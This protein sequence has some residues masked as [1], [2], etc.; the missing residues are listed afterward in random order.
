MFARLTFFPKERAI[1]SM[2]EDDS[3]NN[4]RTGESNQTAWA[5]ACMNVVI[6]LILVLAGLYIFRQITAIPEKGVRAIKN[7][8][9]E[10][11]HVAAAFNRGT[12]TTTFISYATQVEGSSRFQFA[13]LKQMEIFERKDE[14]ATGFG[15]I[16]LPDV[17]AEARA[18]VEFTY[19][20]DFNGTWKII[21]AGEVV[22]VLTPPIQFNKPAVD[23][24]KIKY[25]IKKGSILRRESKVQEELKES[26]TGLSIRRA[27]DNI[28]LVRE[29]GRKEV[30]SFVKKWLLKDFSDGANYR[31]TV[32]FPD[33]P[34]P[35]AF[36][37]S[38]PRQGSGLS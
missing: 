21:V 5:R 2:M 24:S 9:K 14:R 8:L 13:T 1:T 7:G 6:V 22:C 25:E 18:P 3:K 10:L 29:Q 35:A 12:I 32:V 36:S 37:L 15:F 16:P 20:L 19:Y 11:V 33:E 4:R 23:A 26:V 31:V 27:K 38:T 34:I 30:E 28:P 17:I